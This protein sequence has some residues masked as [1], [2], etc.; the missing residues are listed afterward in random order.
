MVKLN[1]VLPTKEREK[2]GDSGVMAH[3]YEQLESSQPWFQTRAATRQE[4]ALVSRPNHCQ[5]RA[6][7]SYT[8]FTVKTVT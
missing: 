3:L 7:M 4:S 1:C 2:L 6:M 8:Y 5:V